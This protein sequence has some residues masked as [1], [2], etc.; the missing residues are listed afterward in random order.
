M[1][2]K[3]RPWIFDEQSKQFLSDG[4]LD[5]LFGKHE[6][7]YFVRNMNFCFIKGTAR[8]ISMFAFKPRALPWATIYCPFRAFSFSLIFILF[9]KTFRKSN[10][11]LR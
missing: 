11:R 2:K 9:K 3:N 10:F 8:T 6:D 1:Q 4:I 5:I 7:I